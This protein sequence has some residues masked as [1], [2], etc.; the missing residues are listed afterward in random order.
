MSDLVRREYDKLIDAFL[1]Y[2]EHLTT[3][4]SWV[5]RHRQPI[6]KR[7]ICTQGTCTCGLLDVL[8]MLRPDI[9]Y[10]TPCTDVDTGRKL[11]GLS[12]I[13]TDTTD[14][15]DVHMV[16]DNKAIVRILHSVPKTDE[17]GIDSE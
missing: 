16:S 14:G 17:M 11:H 1:L 6:D 10:T 8:T 12:I 5:H 7:A 2:A 4:K 3:C 15:F 13:E 9:E